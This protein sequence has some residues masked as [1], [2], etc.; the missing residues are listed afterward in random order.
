MP[1]AAC[2]SGVS[3]RGEIVPTPPLVTAMPGPTGEARTYSGR[4]SLGF[5]Q[6]S[7]DGC[8]L[9]L[10]RY[11]ESFEAPPWGSGGTA[12]YEISFIGRRT[13]MIVPPGE[14]L[15]SGFGHLG[16]SRCKYEIEQLLAS[17]RL[18]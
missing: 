13:D 7:F 14:E 2:Q 5:E 6:S 12:E 4:F 18:W 8:W 1:L 10:G 11:H 16:L 9:D 15:R 3:D 17:R